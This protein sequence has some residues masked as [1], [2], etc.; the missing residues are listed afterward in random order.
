MHMTAG[1]LSILYGYMIA[2]ENHNIK[3]EKNNLRITG[4]KNVVPVIVVVVDDDDRLI[5]PDNLT[6]KGR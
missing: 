6:H 1:T 4:L 5:F 2:I 3:K